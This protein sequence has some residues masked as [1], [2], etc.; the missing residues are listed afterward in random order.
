MLIRF[1]VSNFLSFNEEV[2]LSMIPGKSRKH[3]DHVVSSGNRKT[4]RVLKAAVIYGA[5]AAGKSNL[6]KA[7]HFARWVVVRGVQARRLFPIK[8]FRFDPECDTKPCTFQ[9]EFNYKSR[10][11]SY[12]FSLDTQRIHEEWLYE[13]TSTSEKPIFERTTSDEGKVQVDFVGVKFRD[14]EEQEYLQFIGKGTRIN[15]LFLTETIDRG[16]NRFREIF[17]WFS[18]VLVVIS[19]NSQR[20]NLESEFMTDP[21]FNEYFQ[22]LL[23]SFD[24]GISSIELVDLDFTTD[25]SIPSELRA[26]LEEQLREKENVKSSVSLGPGRNFLLLKNEEGV[27]EGKKFM[28]VH[29]YRSG[30]ALLESFE[31]SDGTQRLFHLIP[32]L[33]DLLQGERVVVID[34]IDRS[35][36]PQLSYRILDMFLQAKGQMKSQMI[37]TTHESHL[38]DLAL[39]RRDEIWFVEK[40]NEG[41]STVYS[42]EEFTPRY[43]KDIQKGY[44]LGRFGAIPFFTPAKTL[45]KI[46]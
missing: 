43:D 10:S 39:L 31:E 5:N 32:A 28:T 26:E 27:I 2:E 42:L 7:I 38:L 36:H 37:V 17:D 15:G 14:R 4:G 24:T 3:P 1:S 19:P 44:L 23:R 6:I 33:I 22:N 40:D 35:L 34:E 45:E 12:G 9:F 13:I 16:I 41:Q 46:K 21:G 18:N 25:P 30:K 8:T 29:K 20:M 11:Y